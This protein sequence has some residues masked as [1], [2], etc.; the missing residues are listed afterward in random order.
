[1]DFIQSFF[2]NIYY[3]SSKSILYIDFLLLKSLFDNIIGLGNYADILLTI[4]L[5]TY[6]N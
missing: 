4:E 6:I 5:N 3:L 1:L 2:C